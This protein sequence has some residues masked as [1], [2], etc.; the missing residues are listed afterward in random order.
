MASNHNGL[1]QLTDKALLDGQRFALMD[2]SDINTYETYTQE[3][4]R[5]K[6][7]TSHRVQDSAGVVYEATN[8]HIIGTY[9]G[10]KLRVYSHDHIIALL[11]TS[12]LLRIIEDSAS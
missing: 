3:L 2:D 1:H 11:V 10:N 9:F 6:E 7:L 8:T 5:R 12:G 4:E